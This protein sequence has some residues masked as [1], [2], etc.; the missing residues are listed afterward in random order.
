LHATGPYRQL[1]PRFSAAAAYDAGPRRSV[2]EQELRYRLRDDAVGQELD[3]EGVAL[4]FGSGRF[5]RLNA[6]GMAIWQELVQ[7]ATA[8]EIAQRVAAKFAGEAEAIRTDIA[9]YLAHLDELGLV[10]AL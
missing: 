3:N 4:D 9:A 5:F 8:T 7:G 2:V 10:D 1:P 6:S